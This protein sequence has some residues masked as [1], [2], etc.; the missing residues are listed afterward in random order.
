MSSPYYTP[1]NVTAVGSDSSDALQLS[2]PYVIVTSSSAGSGVKLVDNINRMTAKVTNSSG[3]AVKVYPNDTGTI[4]DFDNDVPFVLP[5][6]LTA[7]FTT[8]DIRR[9][10]IFIIP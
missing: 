6:G 9:W 7:Y 1:V 8:D 5:I 10:N 2:D 3:N 4:N